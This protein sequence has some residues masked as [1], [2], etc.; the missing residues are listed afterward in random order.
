M[1]K[2]KEREEH[3]MGSRMRATLGEMNRHHATLGKKLEPG[4]KPG[5]YLGRNLPAGELSV[6]RPC[7]QCLSCVFREEQKAVW[8]AGCGMDGLVS[9]L[10]ALAGCR[11]FCSAKHGLKDGR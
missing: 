8:L 4:G 9:A 10:G 7:G 3:V 11:R 6:P 5:L 2:N 1:K